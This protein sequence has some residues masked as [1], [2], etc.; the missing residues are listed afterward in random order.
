[1]KIQQI[2]SLIK[3]FILQQKLCLP[4]EGAVCMVE[5]HLAKIMHGRQCPPDKPK[6][7]QP[8]SGFQ[9]RVEASSSII[10]P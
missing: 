3:A 5:Q 9:S 8:E 10:G 7:V 2:H 1:M 4:H 6:F